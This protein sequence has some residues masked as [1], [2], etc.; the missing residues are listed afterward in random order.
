MNELR[1]VGQELNGLL[2][3]IEQR[4]F[5]SA[6]GSVGLTIHALPNDRFWQENLCGGSPRVQQT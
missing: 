5:L 3:R 2:T 6:E 1:R 4:A